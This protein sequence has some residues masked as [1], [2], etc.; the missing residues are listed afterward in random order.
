M[1]QVSCQTLNII[2][3][4]AKTLVGSGRPVTT[5]QPVNEKFLNGTSA[6]GVTSYEAL[7]HVHVLPR[8]CKNMDQ[9]MS[10]LSN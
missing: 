3:L 6:S 10:E 1:C 7:A 2:L 4:T 9:D 8:L 5:R